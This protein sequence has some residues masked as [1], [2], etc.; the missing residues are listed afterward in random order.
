MSTI[1]AIE[2]ATPVCSI[3]LRSSGGEVSEKRIQGSGVHSDHTFLF[4]QQLMDQFS[5]CTKDLDIVLFSHGPGSY[6]GLRIGASAIKGLLFNQKVSLYSLSSLTSIAAPYLVG[7]PQTVHAVIDA[8][9]EHLYYQKLVKTEGKELD[10]S[11]EKILKITEIESTI[12]EGEIITGTGLERIEHLPKTVVKEPAEN[13]VTAKNL[14]LAW[15]DLNLKQRFK[16]REV[17]FF[18]PEYLS[19]SQL[20]IQ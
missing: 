9:R 4:I 2:T 18:E 15:H 20:K 13:S 7:E 3:A 17:D 11:K 6:T 5:I 12:K 8:R 19:M 1:L 14:I 10:I 16:K